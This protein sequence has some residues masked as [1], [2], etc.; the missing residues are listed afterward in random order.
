LVES[1]TC[2]S[3][4]AELRRSFDEHGYVLLRGVLDRADV[5]SARAEV[6]ERLAAV[7][8]VQTPAAEGICTGVSFRRE[9]ASDLGAFWK[10]VSEG[11][12]LRRVSHGSR[13][14]ELVSLLLNQP[15]RPHDYVFLRPSPVGTGTDLHYD[16]PYF[17]WGSSYIVTCWIPLGDILICE[18]PLV[19]VEGSHL[20]IGSVQ[21]RE[22]TSEPGVSATAHEA[23]YQAIARGARLLTTEFHT[24]DLIVFSPL[25]IHG[26]L[27]NRSPVGRVRLSVDVRYQRA[28]DATDDPRFF[29]VN[30]AGAAGG[31]YGEQIAAQPLG[32][33][34]S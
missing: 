33:S 30:P 20:L 6:F 8:E 21:S 15:T 13:V 18:G 2:L 17:A 19:I 5:L 31:G 12:A 29:G 26:S 24:G 16:H 34:R 27:D 25:T 9:L 28:V 23:A 22:V 7:G 14:R 3:D 32:T 10:S 1:T 4:A 11:L